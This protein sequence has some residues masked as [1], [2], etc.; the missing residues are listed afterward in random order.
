[1]LGIVGE[2]LQEAWAVQQ[3]GLA[4]L[5][6]ADALN[7]HQQ[8]TVE[9][10][11]EAAERFGSLVTEMTD[12]LESGSPEIL[13]VSLEM[14][15]PITAVRGFAELLLMG[16]TGPLTPFQTEYVMFIEEAANKLGV[17]VEE[18]FNSVPPWS[19]G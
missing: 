14:R 11:I 12:F 9:K 15:T 4:L 17:L 16:I 13:N 1:M 3:T 10:I 7:E 18:L 8:N 6:V 2:L 5:E 19:D